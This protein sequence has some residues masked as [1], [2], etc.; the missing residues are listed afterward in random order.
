MNLNKVGFLAVAAMVMAVI[1]ALSGCGKT[2]STVS[3][4]TLATVGTSAGENTTGTEDITTGSEAET[5]AEITT[6][7]TKTETQG[8]TTST[9]K[10]QDTTTQKS[11]TTTQKSEPTTTKKPAT[12]TAVPTQPPVNSQDAVNKVAGQLKEW[13]KTTV[14]KTVSDNE[15]KAL[16]N[17]C[18][19]VKESEKY[20]TKTSL[21][22]F[23]KT[24]TAFYKLGYARWELA[25]ANGSGTTGIPVKLNDLINNSAV[26][27]YTDDFE[28]EMLAMMFKPFNN[29]DFINLTTRMN[30]YAK[31]VSNE[32]VRE[33]IQNDGNCWGQIMEYKIAE[34]EDQISTSHAMNLFSN[35]AI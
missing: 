28:K 24:S 15:Y 29:D 22:D 7:E 5:T 23:V 17:M 16:Q 8:T 30:N 9:S 2:A 33:W 12:T 31:S 18:A 6:A 20:S 14:G 11:D 26:K 13:Y 34:I 10:K 32:V 27:K 35:Y 3:A 1:I 21:P 19:I 25:Y 4:T